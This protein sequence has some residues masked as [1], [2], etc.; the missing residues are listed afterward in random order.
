MM[1][2]KIVLEVGV[3]SL[4]S[5]SSREDKILAEYIIVH[6]TEVGGN[7]QNNRSCNRKE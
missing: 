2:M 7:A 1:L 4:F 3:V 5:I 6:Y